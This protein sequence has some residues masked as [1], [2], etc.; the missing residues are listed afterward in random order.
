MNQIMMLEFEGRLNNLLEIVEARAGSTEDAVWWG[1]VIGS[2]E[3][4]Q[5]DSTDRIG[6]EIVSDQRPAPLTTL[7]D[8]IEVQSSSFEEAVTWGPVIGADELPPT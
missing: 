1:P 5:S 7:I 3:D 8:M 4:P 6:S 2:D